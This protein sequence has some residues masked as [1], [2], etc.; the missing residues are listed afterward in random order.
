MDDS[1]LT[2]IQTPSPRPTKTLARLINLRITCTS[3]SN[4]SCVLSLS[5][6]SKRRL[7]KSFDNRTKWT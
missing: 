5:I 2:D 3:V 7:T 6:K 4:V 1:M